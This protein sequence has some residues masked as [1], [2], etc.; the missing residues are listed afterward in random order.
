MKL[1]GICL[2]KWEGQD[3]APLVLGSALDVNNFGY[4]QAGVGA[5]GWEGAGLSAASGY[6]RPLCRR[7]G[8]QPKGVRV[9]RA[10]C[11]KGGRS[12]SG[13]HCPPPKCSPKNEGCSGSVL[14]AAP[15]LTPAPH[16]RPLA[17]CARRG[18]RCARASCSS[19]VP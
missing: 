8:A 1:T 3:K 12:S 11:V 5:V 9:W 19:R 16:A 4:F 7:V 10:G 18:R 17:T 15:N 2:L 14:A 6:L 13:A